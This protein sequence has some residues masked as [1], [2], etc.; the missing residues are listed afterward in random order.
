MKDAWLKARTE[1]R[2]K[3]KTL[4]SEIIARTK[5]YQEEYL[6]AE[7]HIIDCKRKVAFNSKNI[8]F[9][10]N[11]KNNIFIYKNIFIDLNEN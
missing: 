1:R 6:A 11:N 10:K 8:Y 7:R 5:K 9:I 3:N 2:A 4:R